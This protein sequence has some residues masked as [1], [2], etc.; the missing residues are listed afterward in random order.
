MKLSN[1]LKATELESGRAQIGT[2]E[3]W[4]QSPHSSPASA[5]DTDWISGRTLPLTSYVTPAR[6]LLSTCFPICKSGITPISGCISFLGLPSQNTT[7][8]GFKQQI[9]HFL[10]VLEARSS[11]SKCQQVWFV[12]LAC[13][14]PL[15]TVSSQGLSPVLVHVCDLISSFK[16]AAH[17]GWVRACP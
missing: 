17:I 10:T 12:P 8:W 11:R 9:I 15:L 2:Q 6:V 5:E 14:C 16:D 13:R 3:R 4:L 1:L 7:D